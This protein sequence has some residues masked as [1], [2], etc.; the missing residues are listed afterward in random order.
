MLYISSNR[1]LL[2]DN[3]LYKLG[4]IIKKKSPARLSTP[5]AKTIHARTHKKDNASFSQQVFDYQT[6]TGGR[7][8]RGSVSLF[9]HSFMRAVEKTIHSFM[10]GSAFPAR[11]VKMFKKFTP[12][13]AAV[14]FFP[15]IS[16]CLFTH[17]PVC[18]E[19][20]DTNTRCICVFLSRQL[21]YKTRFLSLCA[22]DTALRE[23]HT[24]T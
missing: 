12:K 13:Y 11:A 5:A 17:A 8:E 19:S 21:Y 14:S 1:S 22:H 20:W 6:L 10:L 4:K 3:R 24:E 16:C 9:T 15:L 7:A 23:T 18:I 2:L